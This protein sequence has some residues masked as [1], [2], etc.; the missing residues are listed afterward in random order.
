MNRALSSPLCLR[1]KTDHCFKVHKLQ[2]CTFAALPVDDCRFCSVC[3]AVVTNGSAG[4]Q[5]KACKFYLCPTCLPA[6]AVERDLEKAFS[7]ICLSSDNNNPD[8]QFSRGMYLA[9][10]D[11]T[12]PDL[13]EAAKWLKRAADQGHA[14]AQFVL[15]TCYARGRGVKKSHS[16][17][18]AWFVRAADQQHAAAQS[19]LQKMK[20]TELHLSAFRGSLDSV[21]AL[22]VRHGF[23]QPDAGLDKTDMCAAFF[24]STPLQL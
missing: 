5:C 4:A 7:E 18:L 12:E 2:K 20:V 15:G 9:N 22:L 3:R 8:A 21:K 11:L 10:G 6:K 1:G 13:E 16:N 24:P 14:H 17:A 23:L 19:K